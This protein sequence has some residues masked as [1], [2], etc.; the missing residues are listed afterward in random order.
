MKIF[1]YIR[2]F[3]YLATNWN[4]VIAWEIIR[5]ELKGERKYSLNT[6]GTDNLLGLEE[7][8]ID[9]SHATMYM[10][11]TYGLLEQLFREHH[12]KSCKHLLDIGC[13]KGRIMAVAAQHHFKKISGIEISKSFCLDAEENMAGIQKTYPTLQY[14]IIN[15]DAFYYDIPPGVDCIFLFNPFDE[16]ILEGVMNNIEESVRKKPRD[17]VIAYLN[18]VHDEVIREMGFSR[19]FHILRLTYLEASVYIKKNPATPG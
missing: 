11:A 3:F 1:P 13:G 9:I 14:S 4:P 17:L 19:V 5:Q 18:P 6:M 15:N 10:P 7:K 8:G 2:Y 16:I 12:I